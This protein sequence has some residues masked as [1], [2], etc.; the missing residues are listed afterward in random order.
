ML[1]DYNRVKLEIDYRGDIWKI[2]KELIIN[3]NTNANNIIPSN[4]CVELKKW[5]ENL[6]NTWNAMKVKQNISMFGKYS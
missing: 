6:E 4:A 5:Q 3:T 1:S 2:S